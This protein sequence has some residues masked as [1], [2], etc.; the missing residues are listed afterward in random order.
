M[1]DLD[2]DGFERLARM[3]K[4]GVLLARETVLSFCTEVRSLRAENERLEKDRAQLAVELD[5]LTVCHICGD[6]L[7]IMD[8]RCEHHLH[9]DDEL[10]GKE[11]GC[12]Y[13]KQLGDDHA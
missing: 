3:S 12:L 11:C 8:A 7:C 10:A 6:E 13:C 2:L 9:A 5:R 4:G 1:I